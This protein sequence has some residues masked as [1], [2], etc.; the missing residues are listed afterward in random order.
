MRGFKVGKFA[1]QGPPYLDPTPT[2]IEQAAPTPAMQRRK[3]FSKPLPAP[4]LRESA[5]EQQ[6]TPQPAGG[7]L[8]YVLSILGLVGYSLQTVRYY[9]T[10]Q[11]TRRL[12]LY[13]AFPSSFLLHDHR[14]MNILHMNGPDANLCLMQMTAILASSRRAGGNLLPLLLSAANVAA[15]A[16]LITQWFTPK[17]PAI[18][19]QASPHALC[20]SN[21]PK[22]LYCE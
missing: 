13:I 14:Y 20:V 7:W 22:Q 11:G 10:T 9:S 17:N 21:C 18:G 16:V 5:K 6:A 4:A 19:S 3:T 8:T 12:R 2:T 1:S 15:L